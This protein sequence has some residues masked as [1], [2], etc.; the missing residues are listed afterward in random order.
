METLTVSLTILIGVCFLLLGR[1]FYRTPRRIFPAWGL[2]NPEHPGV[3]KLGRVYG[4][5]FIFFGIFASVAVSFSF[6]LRSVPGLALLAFPIAVAGAWLL[7]PKL[8]QAEPPPIDAASQQPRK[9]PLFSKHWKRFLAIAACF[10]G[11]LIVG[12][13]LILSDSEVSKMAVAAAESNRVVKQR[14]G[15]PIKRG[16]FTSGSIEIDGPSGHADLEV[17]ISGPKGKAKIYAVAKKSAGIWKFETLDVAFDEAS[18]RLS[19]LQD[20][21]N[22]SNP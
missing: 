13:S 17:P 20:E 2:L 14:L 5:F 8:P 6:F 19:L 11:V 21:S 1:W 15:D 10:A 16:F 18:P 3:Q 12:V 22:T 4:V 9:Q 7:R